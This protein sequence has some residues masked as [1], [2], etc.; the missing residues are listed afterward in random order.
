MIIE[1]ERAD[2]L[3]EAVLANLRWEVDGAV[4]PV[5]AYFMRKAVGEPALEVADSI[6]HT[7]GGQARSKPKPQVK[8]RFRRDYQD[9]FQAVDEKVV[10]RFDIELVGEDKVKTTSEEL[11]E[12][13]GP[14]FPLPSTLPATLHPGEYAAEL[15]ECGCREREPLLK[16]L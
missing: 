1:S 3:L 14:L 6:A 16:P 5:A 9:I 2:P 7:A 10:S 15:L 12:R 11:D 4:L 13:R 8:T